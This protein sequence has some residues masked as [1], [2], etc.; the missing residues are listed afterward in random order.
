MGST[1][2]PNVTHTRMNVT[3]ISATNACQPLTSSEMTWL[4]PR[5]APIPEPGTYALMLAGLVAVASG[6]RSRKRKD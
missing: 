4:P 1:P 5:A 2:E 3:T 6:A